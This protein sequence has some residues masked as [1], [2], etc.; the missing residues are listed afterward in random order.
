M[1]DRSRGGQR[2]HR[3]HNQRVVRDHRQTNHRV[4]PRADYRR[5]HRRDYRRDHRH[6]VRRPVYVNNGRYVFN[7]GY[8]RSYVRPVIQYRYTNYRVRP[9][10]LVE[11]Y[12]TVPGYVWI[13]GHWDWNGYEWQWNA[14]HYEVDV[15]YQSDGYGYNGY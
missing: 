12:D 3:N 13:A 8:T 5:D 10:I 2:D 9:Q 4:Q 11:N 15:N 7:G 6:V 14:G 1:A